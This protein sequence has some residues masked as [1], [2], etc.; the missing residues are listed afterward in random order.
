M[1]AP[2]RLTRLFD[3]RRGRYWLLAILVTCLAANKATASQSSTSPSSPFVSTETLIL[4]LIGI[5]IAFYYIK[6]MM[7]VLENAAKDYNFP[8]KEAHDTY[9]YS[10]LGTVLA[11]VLAALVITAYGWA[12][13]FLY[14]GPILCMIS[15]IAI[16]YCMSRDNY[17]YEKMLNR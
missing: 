7:T 1:N 12:S 14:L 15:P 3:L 2:F 5:V 13:T 17:R 10:L 6:G 8:D 11:V 16:I 9:K 4:C